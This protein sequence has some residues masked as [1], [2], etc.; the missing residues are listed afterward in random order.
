MIEVY[1]YSAQNILKYRSKSS[2]QNIFL[3]QDDE[4]VR[5]RTR[6]KKRLG[7]YCWWGPMLTL[8][9]ELGISMFSVQ[10]PQ[11]T[12]FLVS[13]NHASRYDLERKSGIIVWGI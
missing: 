9:L 7:N 1:E 12:S 8:D 11:H 6:P 2:E 13:C 5:K 4:V 10:A 3:I